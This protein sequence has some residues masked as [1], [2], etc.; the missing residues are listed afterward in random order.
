M[1]EAR[2]NPPYIQQHLSLLTPLWSRIITWGVLYKERMGRFGDVLFFK[3]FFL[4]SLA[5]AR[6][7]ADRPLFRCFFFKELQPSRG[8]IAAAK[9]GSG[10]RKKKP[11]CPG[12]VSQKCNR[13]T[14][15]SACL[16]CFSNLLTRIDLND[17]Q[18]DAAQL[19]KCALWRWNVFY[20]FCS[21]LHLVPHCE[22]ARLWWWVPFFCF[23]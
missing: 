6:T 10:E 16:Q 15:C 18:N 3:C 4:P 5:L 14:S 22:T 2:S 9:N 7:V 8:K 19:S 21:T 23:T 12:F 17:L 11:I 1:T 20:V 13:C